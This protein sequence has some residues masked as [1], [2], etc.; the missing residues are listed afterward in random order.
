MQR[1]PNS[2]MKPRNT[3]HAPPSYILFSIRSKILCRKSMFRTNSDDSEGE[4]STVSL[5]FHKDTTEKERE[6]R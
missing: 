6:Q 3:A 5:R 4:K 1:V 2:Q